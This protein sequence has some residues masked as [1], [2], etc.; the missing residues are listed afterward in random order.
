MVLP[1]VFVDEEKSAQPQRQQWD[2][3][4]L[5]LAAAGEEGDKEN[6]RLRDIDGGAAESG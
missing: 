3:F 1:H 6:G 5:G 4:M 2:G